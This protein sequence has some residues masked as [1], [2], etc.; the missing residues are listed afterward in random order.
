MNDKRR[1]LSYRSGEAIHGLTWLRLGDFYRQHLEDEGR[2]LEAYLNVCN[3]TTWAPWGTPPK[4]FSTGDSDTLVKATKAACE[5]LRKQ[6][7]P[8]EAKK[9][10]SDLLKAQAGAAAALRKE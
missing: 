10:E 1:Q 6:G 9:L 5:I 8:E 4:P 3:R 2:A 7:K